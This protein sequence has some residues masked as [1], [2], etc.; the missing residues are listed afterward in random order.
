MISKLIYPSHVTPTR[1]PNLP[2]I[3][4][5]IS[6]LIVFIHDCHRNNYS[7]RNTSALLLTQNI[8]H[9][10]KHYR[11][12]SLNAHYMILFKNV[13]DASHI[14]NLARQM[15]LGDVKYVKSSYEDATNKHYGYLLIDLKLD[16]SDLVRLR[17]DIFPGEIHYVYHKIYNIYITSSLAIA[18][19]CLVK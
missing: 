2:N 17:T 14:T 16:T 9:Q 1:V 8:F 15:Y 13:R 7:H 3:I 4:I 12:V 5:K 11:M 18:S 19:L 6:H 10:N